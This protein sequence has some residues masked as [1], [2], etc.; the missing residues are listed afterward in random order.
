MVQKIRNSYWTKGIAMLLV[1]NILAEIIQPTAAMALTG[2]PSQPE[3]QG[4]TPIGTSENVDLASGS[5]NYNIPLLDVGGYPI[6]ISYS[7]GVTMDQEASWVGLGWSLNPGVMNRNMRGIPDDFN[8][9]KIQKEFNMRPNVSAGVNGSIGGELFGFDGESMSA[10][11]SLSF[12]M[13]VN[14]NNY[15]GFGFS[16]TISPSFD[17]ATANSDGNNQEL[18]LGVSLTAS[19]DGLNINP[20]LSF[21]V[22]EQ[23][24]KKADT[25]ITV[26][27]GVGFPFNSRRGFTGMTVNI[28]AEG[29]TKS[30]LDK[31][32]DKISGSN[33]FSADASGGIGSSIS[34]V[35]NTYIPNVEFPKI[36]GGISFSGKLGPTFTGLDVTINVGGYYS[37]QD[38]LVTELN[39]PAFGYLNSQEGQN[40][41]IVLHDFNREKDAAYTKGTPNLPVTNYTYDIY[42]AVGQGVGGMFRPFRNDIG[43]VYDNMMASGGIDGSLGIELGAGNL[44]KGGLDIDV[45][46]S[47][48]FSKKWSGASNKAKSSFTFQKSSRGDLYEPVYFK[49]V[50]ELAVDEDPLFEN[51]QGYHPVA[52]RLK[53]PSTG[54]NVETSKELYSDVDYSIPVDF[55][56]KRSTGRS[57]R[58]TMFS[59]LTKGEEAYAMET[60]SSETPYASNDNHLHEL[61]VTRNDGVRYVYGIPAYNTLQREATFNVGAAVNDGSG[62][63]T[64][65]TG[66]NSTGNTK[67][68]D[69]YFERTTTPPFAH[70]YLLTAVISPDYVDRTNDGPTRDDFGTYTKFTYDKAYADYKWRVPYGANS[71]NFNEGLLTINNDNKGSY[72]YGTKEIWYLEKIETKTHVA[73]FTSGERHDAN[74]V[75]GENGGA[76][77][78]NMK[79]L[80]QISLYTK[81]DYDAH[82]ANLANA[83]PIKS[84][85]FVYDY[86]LCPDVENN[87]GATE[88]VNGENINLKKGKLT[89][90]EIYFSYGKSE[91]AK[92]SGYKFKYGDLDLDGDEDASG[93]APYDLKDY[94]MWGS[95]KPNWTGGLTNSENPYVVQNKAQEDGYVAQWHLTN[96]VMPSGGEMKVKY[97]SNDYSHVQ[98]KE[99]MQFFKVVG[100][101]DDIG[102]VTSLTGLNKLWGANNLNASAAD[103]L[104]TIVSLPDEVENEYDTDAE[105]VDNILRPIGDQPIRFNYFMDL[106][107]DGLNDAL[108]EY[109]SGYG[110][111]DRSNNYENAGIITLGGT[112]NYGYFKFEAVP[113]ENKD[114]DPDDSHPVAKAAW[115]W[116]RLYNPHLAYD[117]NGGVFDENSDATSLIEAMAASINSFSEVFE[118][119]NGFIRKKGIG[120]EFNTTKSWVRLGHSGHGK[121]G[122]GSRV[123]QISLT[124][125]WDIMTDAAAEGDEYGQAYTYELAN[126]K[127]SGVASFEPLLSK[128]NPLIVPMSYEEKRF[129][130]P[131]EK[132]MLEKPYGLSFYPSPKVTYSRVE[133]R[134]L[135]KVYNR[136]STDYYSRNRTGKTVTEFYTTK[137]F[138]TIVRQTIMD[139]KPHT[140]DLVFQLL[141]LNVREHATVSQGYVIELNDMDGKLKSQ[142][143]FAEGKDEPMSGVIYRYGSATE[144]YDYS[145]LDNAVDDPF[146]NVVVQETK[147]DNKV[148]TIAPDG[149]VEENLIGVEYDIITDFRESSTE[150]ISAGVDGNLAGFLAAILPLAVPTLLPTF[151]KQSTRFRSAVTTKVINRYGILRETIAFDNGAMVSTENLA[152]DSETGSV[153]LSKT[154]NEFG[155]YYYSMNY[156][157]HWSY[158]RMGQAYKNIM[159]TTGN[160]VD[161]TG[162]YYSGPGV[163]NLVKGDEVILTSLDGS[164]NFLSNQKAWVLEVNSSGYAFFIDEDGA[165]STIPGS[166]AYAKVIRSGR[167]NQHDTSVGS[168]VLK[169]N[170][171]AESN[172]TIK[173]LNND[174]Y[175]ASGVQV[176]NASA[177]EFAEDW[178]L[179]CGGIITTPGDCECNA[180]AAAEDFFEMINYFLHNTIISNAILNKNEVNCPTCP[181]INL[182]SYPSY[183]TSN[184]SSVLPGGYSSGPFL[185]V[186]EPNANQIIFNIGDAYDE[187]CSITLAVPDAVTGIFPTH[188]M[189]FAALEPAAPC[190]EENFVLQ[191]NQL[192]GSGAVVNSYDISG[193]S[194]CF[195]LLECT[196]TPGS[197][198]YCGLNPGD[199]VN[200]F[201]ENI[202]GVW[203]PLKGWARLGARHQMDFDLAS[204]AGQ[205]INTR[206]EGNYENFNYFWKHYASPSAGDKNWQTDPTNWTWVTTIT[207]YRGYDQDGMERE[208][209]DALYR[210]SSAVNGYANTLPIAVAANATYRQ[211]AFDGFEDYDYYT[212]EECRKRHFAFEDAEL[213]NLESHTG[214]YSLQL[215][216]LEYAELSRDL[217]TDGFTVDAK[218]A[219]YEVRE[220]ECQ[221]T[222]GPETYNVATFSKGL[223]VV[224]QDKKYV[225]SFW[226]KRALMGP[227]V[228][229]YDDVSLVISTDGG[230]NPL[231]LGT[232]RLSAII[233]GWQK[234]EYT[235]TIV[236]DASGIADDIS[237]KFSNDGSTNLYIDD[238]RIQ[239]FSSAMKTYVYDPMNLRLMAQLDDNNFATFYEYDEE[240]KLIRIKKETER[241][242]MTIQESRNGIIK[243]DLNP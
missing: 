73:V 60:G 135:D 44:V 185:Y 212:P 187:V 53:Y 81:P 50:G 24:A 237:V 192:N 80:E 161:Q 207:P 127:S 51:M 213:T 33:R 98:D 132:Y 199:I 101:T 89:L 45:N 163:A 11:A 169:S 56:T 150:N 26:G 83:T 165:A 54:I 201:R 13:G 100:A 67:G 29:K 238:I 189:E 88:T 36:N 175:E 39:I 131:S 110:K 95:Y 179:Q 167:R 160:I 215:K 52:I 138:P 186:Y 20:N 173:D 5:F 224:A 7:S 241:G 8:G 235:F 68:V 75:S 180:T 25:E 1:I 37:R 19:D 92:L 4:F 114:G 59:Y 87:D 72:V 62:I 86:Y 126:G 171:I 9:E 219:P 176:I 198:E 32:I 57:K 47:A 193:I 93:N 231:S 208:N 195:D 202:Q 65:A 166:N 111:I 119:P 136:A 154:K 152:W 31:I 191:V 123:K 226:V 159:F 181:L 225:V 243:Q 108:S 106:S 99:A 153:L 233:D 94:N 148:L 49:Q 12:G 22:K 18:G 172:G 184:I 232:P 196:G 203:R 227:L 236:G 168:V 30:T 34:F 125:E 217:V 223:G 221:G 130:V 117:Q 239:P 76:G 85:H 234:V 183:Y 42:T 35:D 112:T 182:S 17:F 177:T 194:A 79:K 210:F 97:E 156:P 204:N 188:R 120:K 155:D 91:K 229:T 140:P 66:D 84:V 220:C 147:L 48:Q 10:N 200:P 216:A 205:L 63:V 3:V 55:P 137:D 43:H 218:V 190:D 38:L 15:N 146:E 58:N 164:G 23:S 230:V 90:R 209:M 14:W 151:S 16:M 134:S 122:G 228:S 46:M 115:Q 109:V 144:E 96:V 141:K 143:I 162:G 74:E 197:T 104:Y 6:N 102:S 40:L 103:H 158:E 21:G 157:A 78:R 222:F 178:G 41:Q 77:T 107:V 113:E 142:M 242:I 116:V 105:F 211:I 206:V 145:T 128:E 61:T 2:G 28:S 118:G 149:N 69:H 133:V 70:A 139:K 240:G 121:L 71:A 129:G 174:S 124:D 82:V 64:Y 170:P 214:R 27:V